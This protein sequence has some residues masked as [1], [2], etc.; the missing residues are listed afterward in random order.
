MLGFRAIRYALSL[1]N[2]T[3]SGVDKLSVDKRANTV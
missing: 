3:I 1:S 2:G